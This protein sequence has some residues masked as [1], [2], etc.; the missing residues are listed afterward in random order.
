MTE[1]QVVHG[2]QCSVLSRFHFSLLGFYTHCLQLVITTPDGGSCGYSYSKVSNDNSPSPGKVGHITRV[3]VP[4]SFCHYKGST[5]LLIIKRRK[6]WSGW[7]LNPQPP[8][9]RLALSQLSEPG[10]GLLISFAKSAFVVGLSFNFFVEFYFIFQGN[11]TVD[12]RHSIAL[13]VIG[14]ECLRVCLIFF[15]VVLGDSKSF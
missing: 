1:R 8:L 15:V 10:G 6:C 11:A 5:F 3:S 13:L 2:K 4:Y 9:R 7:G 12:S 14:M